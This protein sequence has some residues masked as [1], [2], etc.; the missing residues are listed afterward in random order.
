MSI[1]LKD[2]I[3][4]ALKDFSQA[5]ISDCI[6]HLF[7]TLGYS[8]QREVLLDIQTP[9][10]VV[11][12]FG[13]ENFREDKGLLKEWESVDCLFQVTEDD[14]IPPNPLNKGKNDL[15]KDYLKSYIFIGITL[16]NSHYSRSQ[17]ATI[18]R[19]INR[20]SDIPIMVLF[21]YGNKKVPFSKETLGGSDYVT[22][23]IINRRP[24]KLDRDKDV[25]EKITLIKD[26]NINSPHRAH[27]EILADLSLFSLKDVHNF[28]ELHTAWQK[29]LNT[30]ELNKKFFH[31][32]S[33]W[34]FWATQMVTFPDGGEQDNNIRNATSVIRLITRL[35]F[36][37]FLKE[38]GLV[39]DALFDEDKLK[40][41]LKSLES[42]DST[43]YKAILQNLFFATL[44][45]EM[46][47]DKKADN[48]KFRGQ[49]K[50]KG[51]RD[52]HYGIANVYR[53]Q[54]YFTNSDDFLELCQDIPF[55]NGGLFES[56][57][58][59][60]DDDSQAS[61]QGKEKTKIRIDGFSD[62]EEN[63]LSVPNVL[64]FGEARKVDLNKAYGTSNK[65]YE[66]Q[67]LINIFNRYKFTIDENTPI[68]EEIALDPEL[69]GKV[70]ENLL[71]EYNPETESTARK[72]TGSFY[73]P[74]EI[75][76]YMVD[77]SLIA[78]LQT[79]LLSQGSSYLEVG[80][81]QIDL[82]GNEYKK[83]QLSLQ[84]KLENSRF[85]GR[86]KELESQLRSLLSYRDESHQ[87]NEHEC[88]CLINAIDNLK[89]IDI[90]CGSGAFPMGILQKLVFILGKLDPNNSKWKQQQKEKAIQP[91]LKDIQVA[92]QISYEEA[93]EEAI[94][95]LQARLAEI[96]DEFENNEMDYPRKLFLI[97]NCI[98]GV[99]I[100][101]IAVQISKLR[102]FISL[103]VD[104]KVNNAR[105]N[106]GI[107][108][109]PNLETK[110]VAANSLI[111]I[112]TQLS[113]RSPEVIKKEEELKQVRQQHF[114]ART[115]KTKRNCREKDKNLRQEISQLLKSTGLESATADTLA[116]WNPYDLNAR[117][118]FFDPT[119]MFGVSS[120]DI[121]IG[122]PPYIRIQEL[123]KS[124]P[125]QVDYFK[126]H[127]QA[128]KKGN[129][130]IYVVFVEKGI[131]LLNEKGNLAYI[132]PHKFFNAQYG[133]GL[134]GLISKGKYLSKVVHFGDQ[135]VFNSATTYTC[136]LFLDKFGRDNC[137]FIKVDN[138]QKWHEFG[139]A[140][141]EQ[142]ESNYFSSKDWNFNL[143][144][145]DNLLNKLR[146]GTEEL[147]NITNKISQGIRTS[148]NQIYVLKLIEENDDYYLAFSKSLDKQVEIEKTISSQFLQGRQ[149]KPYTILDCN[150][151][152]I[153]PYDTNSKLIVESTLKSDYPKAYQYLL[154][155]KLE[156]ENREK[157]K[158]K[159]EKWYAYIY[160]KNIELM[161][162]NKLI[163]PDIA[164]QQSFAMDTDGN[165]A[166]TSGYGIT[167]NDINESVL[168]I[169]G[170]LNSNVL[171]FY[172]KSISTPIRGGYFRYFTQFIEQLPIT[173]IN[174]SN[175]NKKSKHD[176]IVNLVNKILE[177]KRQNPKANTT[178]LEREID[179][180]VYELYGLN[181]EEI[182]IIEG[183]VK[184]K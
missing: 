69:L 38:K 51:G 31:E 141:Q 101:P 108:P 179:E 13:W 65:K 29:V 135:Q 40:V 148:A 9:D 41:F 139:E 72:Q 163:I 8:T 36:V 125:L 184:R 94:H 21:R 160:P 127:Y 34:Y 152:V 137:H 11:E 155:N 168:Y 60:K 44:N 45:T 80:S 98:F 35:I 47:T 181:E 128:A 93:R 55:L 140:V 27:I 147:K 103:I 177:I 63:P 131:N 61:Q 64:F 74:R 20:Q 30:S 91:V 33:N 19:E 134:R 46:N 138:P 112:E 75:V 53:Y 97:E 146:H 16:Q 115:P 123:N 159:G 5:S 10:E 59:Y 178:E 77:E 183:S 142:F 151:I 126:K 50:Q 37:W 156:L 150:Q 117:S 82:F 174:L 162:T 17:L 76:N 111:G 18:T 143:S 119:W 165:Y 116:R 105:P 149:I 56:L 57:D 172:M 26:I 118:D 28:D 114:K 22:L 78:Y 96:E 102:F 83:G 130:D 144:N 166:F 122:N 67:G 106:R 85:Q 124:I 58:R 164:E 132:L 110:F 70:F 84:A 23:S 154:E 7:E 48:R 32:V 73:T 68:E 81:N 133:E 145:D 170:L 15:D 113:L 87:F 109:L 173:R 79:A 24:N 95:K 62:R 39:T 169:L 100:Q 49:T 158:M 167:F 1:N 175:P 4:Q 176:D 71:A 171:D 104:Q 6:K 92:K 43:Y 161:K 86:E 52:Q 157:G 88:D 153:I 180:I 107:L 54:N 120:F 42:E 14:L 66:V 3:Q 89:I 136:L 121:C 25:L 90:A 99:D 182:R 12:V 2:N 129:Y